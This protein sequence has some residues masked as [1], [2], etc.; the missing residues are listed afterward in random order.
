[1]GIIAL[2]HTKVKT[3]K[4]PEGADYDR[5]QPDMHE[6]TWG[7]THKW[8]DIV[9]FANFHTVIEDEKKRKAAGGQVRIIQTERTAAYDAKNRAGLPQMIQMGQDGAAAW[10]NFVTALKSGREKGGE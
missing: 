9:L 5:Y 7:L 8:A 1:M 2:C 10:A 6:K 3:F 4:N